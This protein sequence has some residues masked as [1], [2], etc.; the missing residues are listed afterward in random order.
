MKAEIISIGTEIMIGSTLNTNSRFLSRKLVELGIDTY[1]HSS[2][3]DDEDRLTEIVNIAL[4]RADL[5]ITTGGLGPTKDDLTKEVISKVLNLELEIDPIMENNIL[6]MF[7]NLNIHMPN[8]NKK[9]AMKPKGS[10]FILNDIGTAPG[11][12]ISRDNKRIIMLPGPPREVNLMFNKY[13]LPLLKEDDHIIIKS[14]NVI[15]I[16]E[17]SLETQIL[18]LNLNEENIMINTYAKE[19]SIEIKIIAKGNDKKTIGNK[20][21][22]IESI[23]KDKLGNYIYGYDGVSI[24]EVVFNLLLNK[25]MKL[26]LC[27]SCTGGLIASKLTGIPGSSKVFDRGIVSYS[28]E[29]KM[30]VLG[31]S[32]DT[33]NKYGAVS[34]ETAYEMAKGLMDST[35]LDIVA[36]ITGIAGPG[37]GTDEKPIGLTYICIMTR[38]GYKTIKR[39]FNGNRKI[40]QNRASIAVLNEIR[41][42]IL[43]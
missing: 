12:F 5:I 28:N 29:S 41:K 20:I 18:S 21:D 13:V 16:G 11:I 2:V 7:A 17:S 10:E 22:N 4:K 34:E 19:G 25:D 23:L 36:S 8:N 37:G 6:N 26:G 33:L 3:D 15:G 43:K 39:N 9:Q 32:I 38:E 1:Y 30:E 31:V 40:I 14:I 27:E 42:T 35:D 24:E